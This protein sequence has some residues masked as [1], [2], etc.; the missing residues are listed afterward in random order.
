MDI[1]RTEVELINERRPV[2]GYMADRSRAYQREET[3][4]WIYG[5]QKSGLSK[6]GDQSMDIWQTEVGLIKERRPVY[7]YMADRSRAYQREET[8]LWIYGGQKSGLSKRGDQSMDIWQTEVGLIK[9]RIYGRQK[10]DLSPRVG[11]TLFFSAYVRSDTA[12]TI[13]PKKYQEFQALKKNI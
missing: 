7:G 4:L 8:S 13:H 1:W 2:Y 9:E 12:S 5:R 3:T 11:G 10:S 6:R